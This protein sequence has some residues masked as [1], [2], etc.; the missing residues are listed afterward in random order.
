MPNTLQYTADHSHH[1]AHVR[2]SNVRQA[3]ALFLD[4]YDGI[5]ARAGKGVADRAFKEL[6][7]DL[8]L[9]NTQHHELFHPRGDAS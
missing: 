3:I 8:H 2:V 7:R 1:E 4:D 9:A 5:V 6:K